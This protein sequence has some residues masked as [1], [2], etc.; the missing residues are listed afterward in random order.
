MRY[1]RTQEILY[2]INKLKE[3]KDDDE[4]RRKYKTLMR[5]NVFV[6][7]PLAISA[8]E[9]FKMNTNLFDEE[10][11]K[12]IISGD[13]PLEF[14][15]L[16]FTQTV[17]E[18]RALNESKE[19]C[20]IISASGMC[21][22]GRI[23]HHLKHN[24]W[25]P[26]S[27]ILFVGYQAPGTLGRQIVDGAKSVKIFGEEI[28]V[29]ARVEYIEGYSGH[30]DQEWLLNFIYSFHNQPKHI[31]LVH[32]EPDSQDVLKGKILETTGTPVTIPNFGE[33]FDLS[34]DT[35]TMAERPQNLRDFDNHLI[36][37]D[38]LD[39]IETMKNEISSMESNVKEGQFEANGADI[40]SLS[41]KIRELQNEINNM[42]KK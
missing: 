33:S 41:E 21:D 4:F 7:S 22:V 13:N 16:H 36:R 2:E 24:L 31:F 29:N 37:L 14:P 5:A 9:I 39:A 34:G 3:V 40:E 26:N 12:E 30:A 42:M 20:I 35:P 10:I 32:G 6:D 23:K 27:T 25:N 15:G 28:A 1:G 17:E 18:S 19:P 8:T 38:I 11:Q